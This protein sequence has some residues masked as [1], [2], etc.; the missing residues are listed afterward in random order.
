MATGRI[1]ALD[2]LKWFIIWL[3][4]V[5]HG[6]LCYMAYAPW[7]WYVVD[8]AQ[9]VFSATI[10]V[11]W[12]DIF[13]M[14]IMFFVSGYF[15]LMSLNKHGTRKFWRLKLTRVILP[16]LF[17]SVFIAPFVAYIIF[18]SRGWPPSFGEFYTTLFWGPFYQQ[19][20]YWYLGA[21]TALY[22]LLT[23]ARKIWPAFAEPP[24]PQQPS[25]FFFAIL[26]FV[27]FVSLGVISS[28]MPPDT[29]SFFGYILVLQPVRVPMYIAVFF[30]GAIACRDRWLA[31]GGYVP[32]LRHWALPFLIAGLAYVWQRLYLPA[33][34]AANL[35]PYDAP[36]ADWLVWINAFCQA[37]FTVTAIFFFLSI[38]YQRLNFA[39]PKLS[40]LAATSYG[41]YYVHMPIV[42]CL[43]WAFLSVPL[44]VYAKYITVCVLA[45]AACYA[46]ARYVLSL[47]PPFALKKYT[48]ER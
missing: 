46:L 6:A 13:I 23:L 44:N 42:F 19:A 4:V 7:W 11:S 8:T 16:W 3:M 39:S 31:A 5:F 40:L 27:S 38:F 20:Q 17:G 28:Y 21:L 37:L 22:I 15:G 35:A 48:R 41:V 25:K 14:P 12:T 29:G 45:L 2:N 36:A 26:A 30:A 47:L 43:A 9:P 10:F 33:Y 1:Y 32:T 24:R 34:L 18:A